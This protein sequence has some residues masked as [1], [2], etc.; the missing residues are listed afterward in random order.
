MVYACPLH[1]MYPVHT[2]YFLCPCTGSDTYVIARI[3]T[4]I[5]PGFHSVHI[6]QLHLLNS[7]PGKLYK[8]MAQLT[9]C[10][11]EK[12]CGIYKYR[13][14]NYVYLQFK[15]FPTGIETT[16]VH[17]YNNRLN[18]FLCNGRYCHYQTQFA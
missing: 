4:R 15:Q 8:S 16:F 3:H 7:F 1:D 10:R 2:L 6:I 12:P 18:Y 13:L 9:G 5:R 11:T 17:L 14:H